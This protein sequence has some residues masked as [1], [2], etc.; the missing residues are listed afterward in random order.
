[1]LTSPRT[2]ELPRRATGSE[3]SLGSGVELLGE[4]PWV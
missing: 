4:L 1:V 2:A 3:R